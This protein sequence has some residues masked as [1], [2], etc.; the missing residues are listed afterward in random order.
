MLARSLIWPFWTKYLVIAVTNLKLI[1]LTSVVCTLCVY[2]KNFFFNGDHQTQCWWKL[3][4]FGLIIGFPNTYTIFLTYYAI[5]HFIKHM[6][7]WTSMD[8][9]VGYIY[10]LILQKNRKSIKHITTPAPVNLHTEK[11]CTTD[12]PDW[13]R[14]GRTNGETSCSIVCFIFCFTFTT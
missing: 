8:S 2:L 10:H 14:G 13:L 11:Q 12:N 4:M 3:V 9:L 6:H 1:W 7:C 5:S